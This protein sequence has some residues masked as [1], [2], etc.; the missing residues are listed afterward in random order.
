MT[1]RTEFCGFLP[2]RHELRTGWLEPRLKP[3]WIIL[4]SFSENLIIRTL[5]RVLTNPMRQAFLQIFNTSNLKEKYLLG[6][7]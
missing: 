2:I 3:E 1:I 7:L 5:F 4:Q 6:K